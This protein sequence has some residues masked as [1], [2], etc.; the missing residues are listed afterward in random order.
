MRFVLTPSESHWHRVPANPRLPLDM[1]PD[2]PSG[3]RPSSVPAALP[4]PATF[5]GVVG[6]ACRHPIWLFGWQLLV[7]VLAA[8]VVV[9]SVHRIYGRAVEHAVAYLPE[10]AAIREGTLVWSATQPALL[11]QGPRIS[12]VVEPSGSRETGLASDVTVTLEAHQLAVRTPA[13]WRAYPY[14]IDRLIS[15]SP[16]DV[17]SFLLTW[18]TPFFLALAGAVVMGLLVSWWLLAAAY[19]VLLWPL[20][21]AF[22][23]A[24]SLGTVWRL[25]AASLL[26]G[27][28]LMIAAT[29]IY[30][31]GQLNLVGWLLAQPLHLVV[32]WLYCAGSL[33]RL[34]S[35]DDLITTANPF[36]PE[37]VSPEPTAPFPPNAS[38]EVRPSPRPTNPFQAS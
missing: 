12:L 27:A 33:V 37:P 38:P 21:L 1:V 3:E 17:T 8:A 18:R 11:Y 31:T 13:G 19:S 26:P 20:A 25:A 15:L 30:A 24:A 23:R 2:L 10:G 34:P 5:G 16:V 29:A 4:L 35:R 7:A 32:G 14:P 22:R 36:I 6:V 9:G 28:L